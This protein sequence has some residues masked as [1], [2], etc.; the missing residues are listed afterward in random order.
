MCARCDAVLTNEKKQDNAH[1]HSGVRVINQ[2][3][4][5]HEKHNIGK[6]VACSTIC[7]NGEK[8]LRRVCVC[9]VCVGVC[10][11]CA[12]WHAENLRE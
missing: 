10:G 11:G 1:L 4:C 5:L 9:L 2:V 3:L 6:P 12:V 8:N 7:Q